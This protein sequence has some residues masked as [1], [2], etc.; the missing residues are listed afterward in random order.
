MARATMN[1]SRSSVKCTISL[2][3]S[4]NDEDRELYLYYFSDCASLNIYQTALFGSRS[5]F[6]PSEE[7]PI[8][9]EIYEKETCDEEEGEEEAN[10][11]NLQK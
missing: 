11:S 4:K 10:I 6:I 9:I 5:Q 3:R 8:N 1:V 7:H 2:S